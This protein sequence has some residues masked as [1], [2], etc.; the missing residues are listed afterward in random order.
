MTQ[1]NGTITQSDT[2]EVIHAFFAEN[3]LVSQQVNSFNY[4]LTNTI[5]DIVD[6]VGKIVIKPEK[7]YKPGDK[8]QFGIAVL[9]Q[10]ARPT[11]SSSSSSTST[12]SPLTEIRTESPTTCSQTRPDSGI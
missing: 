4:F 9:T 11:S 7:Q 5:Q 10:T 3:G 12:K 1:D 8:R 6:E 2:W